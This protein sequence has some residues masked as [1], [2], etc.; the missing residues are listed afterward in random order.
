MVGSAT[1]LNC[2]MIHFISQRI[3]AFYAC[4]SMKLVGQLAKSSERTARPGACRAA[5]NWVN[6]DPTRL[7]TLQFTSTK[8][9]AAVT[10]SFAAT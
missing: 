6:A 2:D 9:A 8:D 10:I 7:T 5:S 1:Y 4:F 3:R